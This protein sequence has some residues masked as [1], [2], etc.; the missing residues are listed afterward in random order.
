[1]AVACAAIGSLAALFPAAWM[2]LFSDDAEI[3]VTR[4]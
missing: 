2:G 3:V 1:V 4:T